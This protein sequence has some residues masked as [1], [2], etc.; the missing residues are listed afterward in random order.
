MKVEINETLRNFLM[1]LKAACEAKGARLCI[2]MSPERLFTSCVVPSALVAYQY[3]KLGIPVLKDP[4]FGCEA[5]MQYISDRPNHLSPEG[6]RK[7]SRIYA[8]AIR[9]N[10]YWTVAELEALLSSYGYTLD[11]SYH[12]D[13]K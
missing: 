6:T 3:I 5:D 9:N 13:L 1:Q 11:G 7:Y 2:Y 8:E 12:G 10:A 4:T